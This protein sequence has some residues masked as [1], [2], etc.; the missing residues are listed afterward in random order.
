MLVAHSGWGF[1]VTPQAVEFY[2]TPESI[3]PKLNQTEYDLINARGNWGNDKSLSDD[4]LAVHNRLKEFDSNVHW[5]KVATVSGL[6]QTVDCQGTY[7]VSVP[8]SVLAL[9]IYTR[10]V[11]VVVIPF[12]ASQAIGDRTK[13]SEV[14]VSRVA[15]I[16]G[17]SVN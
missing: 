17:E 14:F 6:T 11:K 10:Y 4:Y 12:P 9:Q 7:M 1:D 13:I 16:D 8:Q 3:D 15:T 2:V 5:T